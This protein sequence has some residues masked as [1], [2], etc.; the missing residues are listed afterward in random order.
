[1]GPNPIHADISKQVHGHLIRNSSIHFTSEANRS[2]RHGINATLSSA[3]PS[4]LCE[5]VCSNCR[6][7]G[8][9]AW[10]G[11]VRPAVLDTAS[12]D[13]AAPGLRRFPPDG[14]L[15]LRFDR[16]LFDHFPAPLRR[17]RS[18]LMSVV[19][20]AQRSSAETGLGLLLGQDRCLL[21]KQDVRLLLRQA[22]YLLLR[23][24]TCLL[25]SYLSCMYLS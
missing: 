12:G 23:Q 21:S 6:H 16:I 25:L 22:R 9:C 18:S 8:F 2:Y 14:L 3:C 17:P 4:T 11:R 10:I 5:G 15:A 24:D 19:E 7:P 1:M 13:C 20:A